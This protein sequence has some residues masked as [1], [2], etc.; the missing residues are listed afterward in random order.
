MRTATLWMAVV[1][2]VAGMIRDWTLISVATVGGRLCSAH[3]AG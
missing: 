2:T 3:V 1:T